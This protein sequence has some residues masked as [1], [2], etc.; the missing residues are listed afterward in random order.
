MEKET[1]TTN[2]TAVEERVLEGEE[3][4]NFWNDLFRSPASIKV[5]RE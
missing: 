5:E 1:N 3:L 4:K 2:N